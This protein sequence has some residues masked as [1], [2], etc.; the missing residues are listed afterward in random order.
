MGTYVDTSPY[1]GNSQKL[2]N[3]L[4]KKNLFIISKIKN[5]PKDV[6]KIE[7]YINNFTQNLKNE[8][9]KK[10]FCIF[11]HDEK[12]LDNLKR[13]KIIKNVFLKLK[14]KNIIQNFGYSIY[15]FKKYKKKIFKI[16]PDILQFPYN[17]LDNRVTAKDFK[18][19]KKKK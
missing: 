14:K 4:P 19:L 6:N 7:N 16:K 18:E 1:Y 10:V 2:L 12:D 9:N 8:I 17:L 15:D 13:L 5:I 11:L 3:L